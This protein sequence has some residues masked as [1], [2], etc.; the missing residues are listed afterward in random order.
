MQIKRTPLSC[1]GFPEQWTHSEFAHFLFSQVPIVLRWSVVS[2]GYIFLL[3]VSDTIG[4]FNNW[5]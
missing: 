5:N 1:K 2:E 3:Y 4:Q